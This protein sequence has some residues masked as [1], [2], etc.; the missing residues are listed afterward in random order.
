M[1]NYFQLNYGAHLC[2]LLKST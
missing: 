1:Q 2:E